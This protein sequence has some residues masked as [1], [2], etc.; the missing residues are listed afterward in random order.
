MFWKASAELRDG[1]VAERQADAARDALEGLGIETVEQRTTSVGTE[2]PGSVLTVRLD[3]GGTP[4]GFDAYGAPSNPV[5]DVASEVTD[6]VRRFRND[7]AVVDPYL[8]D[9]LLVFLALAGGRVSIPDVS[10]H[11]SSS[12]RLLETF[13]H[14]VTLDRSS[15]SPVLVAD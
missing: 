12:L 1:D 8:G 11:V 2:S 14:E 10:D 9:Q 7:D 13:G 5:E 6:R 15:E 3:V 4:T